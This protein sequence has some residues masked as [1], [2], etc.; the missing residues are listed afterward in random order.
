KIKKNFFNFGASGF[1]GGGGDDKVNNAYSL[2]INRMAN[3][4]NHIIYRGTNNQSSYS[5][6]FLEEIKN[7]NIK[8]AN[9]VAQNYPFGTSLAFN[10]YWIDTIGGGT[11]GNFQ[12]QT[13]APIA[14]GLL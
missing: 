8:D 13:R 10:T 11:S 12:F 1:I 6:K 14:S 9:A 2:A 4:G 5:Q 3:F 7:G